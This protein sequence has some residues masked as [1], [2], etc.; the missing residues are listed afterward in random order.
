[1]RTWYIRRGDCLAKNIIL[2]LFVAQSVL[3][4]FIRDS[5]LQNINFAVIF[6]VKTISPKHDFICK[7]TFS[8]ASLT[9]D[10]SNVQFGNYE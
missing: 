9:A 7:V 2:I 8:L 4:N 5:I 10:F 3:P 6:V 1:M